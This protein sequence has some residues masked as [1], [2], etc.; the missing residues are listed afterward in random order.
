[1]IQFGE[2]LNLEEFGPYNMLSAL[3]YE[4]ENVDYL[5]NNKFKFQVLFSNNTSFN[6]VAYEFCG[7]SIINIPVGC[8]MQLYHH[9]LLIMGREELLSD[10]GYEEPFIGRYRIDTFI[11]PEICEYNSSYKQIAFYAGPDNPERRKVAE[12][13]TLF[14]MEFLMFHEL[15][16]HLGG[17]IRYL[18]ERFGLTELYA[19][20]NKS[21]LDSQLYQ[22]LEM[23]AD[24]I[25]IS[26]LLESVSTKISFYSK[27]F[28]NNKAELIPHCI[29]VA[30]T[31]VYFL[32]DRD[33]CQS[34]DGTYSK[35]LPRDVRFYLVLQILFEKL[36]NDYQ[37]CAFS[38]KKEN[39]LDTFEVANY[40]LTELYKE[41]NPNKRIMIKEVEIIRFYYNDIV[42]PLW[43]EIREELKLFAAINLPE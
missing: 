3:K 35:Y 20:G 36:N 39:L 23:G 24:A 22:V 10:V 1:M 25:A 19:Q 9:S 34:F 2:L 38:S 30:I 6:A 31:T 40:L 27:Q 43:N 16:H 15:G 21:A 33:E 28:L 7:K 42:L 32:L 41:K 11:E 4:C 13:I 29:M 12:L 17:H 26:T 5:P 14:G 37:I 18:Q 8:A